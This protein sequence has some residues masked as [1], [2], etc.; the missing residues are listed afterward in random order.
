MSFTIKLYHQTHYKYDRSVLLSTHL[1]RLR[2][3]AH[4][5]ADITEY[6]F[7]VTP[8][9]HYY[10]RLQDVF[11]NFIARVDF[12]EAVNEMIVEV[13]LTAILHPVNPF[14]FLIDDYA[15]DFPFKYSDQI[16]KD[17]AP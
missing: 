2:P 17:L 6:N 14:D 15:M 8:S 11:G 10:H 7:K 12:T 5:V 3:A 16:N 9:C 13:E 1:F 4:T